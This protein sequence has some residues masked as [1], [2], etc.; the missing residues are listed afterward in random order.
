MLPHRIT[1]TLAPLLAELLELLDAVG[2]HL[3]DDRW[4][5]AATKIRA[6]VEELRR[7]S[8]LYERVLRI[9]QREREQAARVAIERNLAELARTA[10]NANANKRERELRQRERGELKH[11]RSRL[12]AMTARLEHEVGRLPARA[13]SFLPRKPIAW[14]REVAARLR[15]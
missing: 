1:E 9:E 12:N 13:G 4:A 14:I 5:E 3:E 11:A 10:T 2:A 6:A 7:P 15:R 8:E